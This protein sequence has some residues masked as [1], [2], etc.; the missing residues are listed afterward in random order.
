MSSFTDNKPEEIA[1]TK[2]E[3]D[4]LVSL[5][6]RAAS[7]PPICPRLVE[8]IDNAYEKAMSNMSMKDYVYR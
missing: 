8:L 3:E 7:H 5:L 1:L 2:E 4:M 6:K